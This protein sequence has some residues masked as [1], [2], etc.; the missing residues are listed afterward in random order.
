[1]EQVP[2]PDKIFCSETVALVSGRGVWECRPVCCPAF[3][4]KVTTGM[5]RGRGVTCPAVS[6]TACPVKNCRQCSIHCS[7]AEN[8]CSEVEWLLYSR[9]GLIPTLSQSKVS[10]SLS[11]LEAS[12]NSFPLLWECTLQWNW[13]QS[14]CSLD[15]AMAAIAPDLH[16]SIL[17]GKRLL[18]DLSGPA[19]QHPVPSIPLSMPSAG[20]ER[21]C[22]Y[23]L[24]KRPKRMLHPKPLI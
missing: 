19:K 10:M 4:E 20:G 2:C 21:V 22:V 7:P 3:K 15:C 18:W 24:R 16:C 6:G 17:P 9:E 5:W 11:M 8:Y 13:T 14:S 1:M 12:Q 23:S